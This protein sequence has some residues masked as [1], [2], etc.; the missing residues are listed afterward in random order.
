MGNHAAAFQ[1]IK[2]VP[3]DEQGWAWQ[4]DKNTAKRRP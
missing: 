2:D 3:K 4:L 1:K